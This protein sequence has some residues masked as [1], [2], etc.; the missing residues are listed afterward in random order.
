[1]AN[2]ALSLGVH[3][4]NNKSSQ[5]GLNDIIVKL[6]PYRGSEENNPGDDRQW[7]AD[8]AEAAAVEAHDKETEHCGDEERADAQCPQ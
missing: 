1:M 3:R 2:D 4:K 8:A 5:M 6:H 7:Q